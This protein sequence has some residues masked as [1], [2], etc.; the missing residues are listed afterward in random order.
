MK[1]TIISVRDI[2]A[3]C[4]STPTYHQSKGSALR[5][6]SSEVNRADE[7]NNIYKY[8]GDYEL[9][10]LGYFDDEYATFE[11]LSNPEKLGDARDYVIAKN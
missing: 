6:F 2:V 11:P 9:Y 3:N 8:P 5:A 7:N 1:F 10:C 4:Y